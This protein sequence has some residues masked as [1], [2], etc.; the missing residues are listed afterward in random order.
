MSQSPIKKFSGVML[1]LN[2]LEFWSSSVLVSQ[3][4]FLQVLAQRILTATSMK[5]C[6]VF[7]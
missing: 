3:Y 1:I 7:S 6:V 4:I 5:D 2:M